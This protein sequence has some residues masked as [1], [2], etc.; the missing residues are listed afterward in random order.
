MQ[1]ANEA[2]EVRFQ[3]AR[4]EGAPAAKSEEEAQPLRELLSFTKKK[5]EDD[6]LMIYL[7]EFQGRIEHARALLTD[8][9]RTAVFFATL[10]ESLPI[11]VIRRFIDWFTDFGIPVGGVVVNQV[12]EPGSLDEVLEFVRN[13]VAM[14]AS[15][16]DSV[17][18]E[19]PGLVRAVLPLHDDEIRGVDQ[20]RAT[21]AEL[22]GQPVGS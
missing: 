2:P 20:L 7:V 18:A 13:R 4:R 19:F 1:T 10:P 17:G 9:E 14:Q 6:P 11:A 22:F 12:I 21:A 8:P 5:E 16:L 15:R 3:G